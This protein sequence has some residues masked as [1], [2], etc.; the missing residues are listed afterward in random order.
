MLLNI[1]GLCKSDLLTLWD[2]LKEI[3]GLGV[4]RELRRGNCS[5][6]EQ[7]DVARYLMRQHLVVV[8]VSVRHHHAVDIGRWVCVA[9]LV[10]CRTLGLIKHILGIHTS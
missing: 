5:R 3:L 9:S 4:R 10:N 6:E 7:I 8:D 2:Q 1:L